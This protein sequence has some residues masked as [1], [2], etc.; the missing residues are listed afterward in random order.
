MLNCNIGS[1]EECMEHTQN[2]T[3]SEYL[4]E[5]ANRF[6]LYPNRISNS[7]SNASVRKFHDG[8]RRRM[9]GW[10]KAFA[11]QPES[12]NELLK[13]LGSP[14]SLN[15]FYCRELLKAIPGIVGTYSEPVAFDS[16]RHL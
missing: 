12:D 9:V 13:I 7:R 8:I 15:E 11:P 2:S 6:L 5:K 4:L 16:E 3:L 14:T 10:R 1:H